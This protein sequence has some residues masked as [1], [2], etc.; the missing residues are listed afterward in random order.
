MEG[1]GLLEAHCVKGFIYE[2]RGKTLSFLCLMLGRQFFSRCTLLFKPATL[3]TVAGAVT[4]GN[5]EVS[6]QPNLGTVVAPLFV[7]NTTLKL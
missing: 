4:T 1:C 3:N 2:R 7:F 5:R 6:W